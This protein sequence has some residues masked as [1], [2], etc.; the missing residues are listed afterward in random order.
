MQ[1][2]FV[3][4]LHRDDEFKFS[5]ILATIAAS[6]NPNTN[7]VKVRE[8]F[9]LSNIYMTLRKTDFSPR[10]LL[11]DCILY[12]GVNRRVGSLRAE[13]NSCMLRHIPR[14]RAYY[15]LKLLSKRTKMSPKSLGNTLGQPERA[16]DSEQMATSGYTI[17]DFS[18][19][20][21]KQNKVSFD[22]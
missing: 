13:T 3:Y 17:V 19:L 9:R 18:Y 11:S 21:A 10:F 5:G 14:S 15:N 22:V 4:F 8:K 2:I 1:Q 7:L 16:Y 6:R 12:H 20:L